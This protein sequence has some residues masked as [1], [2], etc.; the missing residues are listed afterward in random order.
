MTIAIMKQTT[1]SGWV[2]DIEFSMG[3][4]YAYDEGV[5]Q[6]IMLNIETNSDLMREF[7]QATNN[8]QRKAVV[9]KS[10]MLEVAS[11]KERLLCDLEKSCKIYPL[12]KKGGN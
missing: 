2:S 10:I 7:E 9:R 8:E 11:F 1:H 12:I 3:G 5:W 4:I 6:N